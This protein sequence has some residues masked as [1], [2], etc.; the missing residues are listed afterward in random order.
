MRPRRATEPRRIAG[1]P[2][3]TGS[4]RI[5]FSGDHVGSSGPSQV[6]RSYLQEAAGWLDAKYP[7]PSLRSTLSYLRRGRSGYAGVLVSSLSNHHVL[8][9]LV[10]R[11]TR[12]R[13][14]YLAHGVAGREGIGRM[15]SR[16][17]TE[18]VTVRLATDVI[19]VSQVLAKELRARFGGSVSKY[20]VVHNAGPSVKRRQPTRI[21][22]DDPIRVLSVGTSPIKNVEVMLD[23]VNRA[24]SPFH[25]TLVGPGSFN[26]PGVRRL[27]DVEHRQLL[28]LMCESDLY[29]QTSIAESFGLAIVEAAASGCELLIPAVAGCV[30][31]M[32]S[33]TQANLIRDVHDADEIVVKLEN[34]ARKVRT[35]EIRGHGVSWSWADAADALNDVVRQSTREIPPH[36]RRVV[37]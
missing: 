23:V 11:L 12:R 17:V 28:E 29:V 8:L 6:N 1:D 14:W 2:S 9:L 35:G 18:W 25:L 30:E 32:P 19:C 34:L 36:S 15:R 27:A 31:V 21:R 16:R 10:S 22:P 26:G 20:R 5:L 33:L 3:T 13:G 4:L 24:E 37:E 7:Q